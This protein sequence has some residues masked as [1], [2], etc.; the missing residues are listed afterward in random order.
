MLNSNQQQKNVLLLA[1]LISLAIHGAIILVLSGA[2]K[3]DK[4]DLVKKKAPIEIELVEIKINKQAILSKRKP[5]QTDRVPIQKKSSQ[6]IREPK[7]LID[8]QT[9]SQKPKR[10]QTNRQRSPFPI[11]AIKTGSKPSN[12]P[13]ITAT[14][15]P[16]ENMTLRQSTSPTSSKQSTAI[17]Q[18]ETPRCR[19]CREPRIPRRAEQRGE[20]GYATF[21]LYISASG[22][23]AKTRLLKSS[24]HAGFINSAR[25]AAMYSTFHPMAQKNTKDI[26]YVMKTNN[27]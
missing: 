2:N 11:P 3:G 17:I 23:V 7:S 13:A 19:Q 14:R 15:N 20:E 26:M 22:K 10:E 4:I 27:K 12:K 5:K 9:K 8:L 16:T 21:R 25:K 18:K 24:G 1:S 6:P